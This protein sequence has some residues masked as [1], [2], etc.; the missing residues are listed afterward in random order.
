MRSS[1]RLDLPRM[2]LPHPILGRWRITW[3]ELWDQDFVDAEG[4][5]YVRFDPDDT[6]EFG[7][8]YV[9]GWMSY[10]LSER[11]GRPAAVWDWHGNDEMHP[12]E[13]RGVARVSPD[14]TLRGRLSFRR[15]DRSDFRAV[16]VA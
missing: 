3:M 4:E 15:G 6:G 2:P 14:G 16:R 13:G 1:H 12:A 7:F 10:Y 9:H 5:G 8:G 11:G